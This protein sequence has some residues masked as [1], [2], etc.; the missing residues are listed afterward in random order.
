MKMDSENS[1]R[2][3]RIFRSAVYYY[4]VKSPE[5]EMPSEHILYVYYPLSF[6]RSNLHLSS[7]R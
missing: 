6:A 1:Y 2:V 7:F 4:T 3:M 5:H